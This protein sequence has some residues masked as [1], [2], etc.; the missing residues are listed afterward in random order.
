MKITEII[1]GLWDKA[2]AARIAATAERQQLDKVLQE[3]IALLRDHVGFNEAG[4]L[5][6]YTWLEWEKT[7]SPREAVHVLQLLE[8]QKASLEDFILVRHQSG[9]PDLRGIITALNMM[10]ASAARN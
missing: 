4:P 8:R 1:I 9:S 5:A 2:E 3:H 10:G 7:H 6:K